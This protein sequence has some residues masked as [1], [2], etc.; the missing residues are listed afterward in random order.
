MSE[1]K[2][3]VFNAANQKRSGNLFNNKNLNLHSKINEPKT[4]NEK[5]LSDKRNDTGKILGPIYK[6]IKMVTITYKPERQ[7]V[8]LHTTL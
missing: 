2:E 7:F 4:W 3:R 6:Q 8:S 5:S 1:S